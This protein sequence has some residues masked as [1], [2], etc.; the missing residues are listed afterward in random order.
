MK[1]VWKSYKINKPEINLV[2]DLRNTIINYYMRECPDE[3]IIR[4]GIILYRVLQREICPPTACS[5]DSFMGIRF[6]LDS[7]MNDEIYCIYRKRKKIE[8]KQAFLGELEDLKFDMLD[9]QNKINDLLRELKKCNNRK[10]LWVRLD[11]L[12]EKYNKV[13]GKDNE[14]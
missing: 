6:V 14:T 2:D 8:D 13:E 9:K 5:T 7:S 1:L 11:L 12:I 4:L 3:Y 10:E